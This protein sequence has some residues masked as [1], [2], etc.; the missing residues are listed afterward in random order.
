MLFTPEKQTEL[1][2]RLA[3]LIAD[4]KASNLALTVVAL[5]FA[6]FLMAQDIERG[7]KP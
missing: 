2:G 4:A 6:A 3:G 1:T 5:E 7:E